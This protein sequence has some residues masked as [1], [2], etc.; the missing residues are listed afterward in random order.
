MK[1]K[2]QSKNQ[3]VIGNYE[4]T[5]NGYKY[6][7]EVNGSSVEMRIYVSRETVL[8]DGCVSIERSA[9]PIGTIALKDSAKKIAIN[10][11]I[12]EHLAV[13]NEFMKTI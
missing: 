6:E 11:E 10:G 13:F 9:F 3:V 12:D 5:N 2:E 7:I 4:V 8:E 1:F